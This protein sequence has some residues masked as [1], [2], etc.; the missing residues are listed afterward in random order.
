[1]HTRLT[2]TLKHTHTHHSLTHS[3][4]HKNTPTCSNKYV[5]QTLAVREF[6][7]PTLRESDMIAIV[8]NISIFTSKITRSC[9]EFRL[10][11]N[12]EGVLPYDQDGVYTGDHNLRDAEP[13]CRTEKIKLTHGIQ[14]GQMP[15][16][17]H[18]RH[19]KKVR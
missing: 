14:N 11:G 15:E 18:F 8:L 17:R 7:I 9:S 5:C 4:A 6:G 10:E 12:T 1:V 2:K 13:I 3:Q 16:F 19:I